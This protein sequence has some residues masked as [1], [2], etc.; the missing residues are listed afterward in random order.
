VSKL[1]R[2]MCILCVLLERLLALDFLLLEKIS[3]ECFEC[4]PSR[5][6]NKAG[7]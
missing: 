2:S 4:L 7:H 1:C 6:G 5:D 3:S